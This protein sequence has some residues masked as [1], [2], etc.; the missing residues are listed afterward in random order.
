M[1]ARIGGIALPV[2]LAASGS[3]RRGGDGVEHQAAGLAHLRSAGT[4]A[5][6]ALGAAV[7]PDHAGPER[8]AVC[9]RPVM[10]PSSWPQTPSAVTSR[11]AAPADAKRLGDGRPERVLPQIAG[12]CSAQPGCG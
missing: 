3:L 1:E 4:S 6:S 10:Q 5:I 9:R 11:G 2:P 7:H 8:A 12:S